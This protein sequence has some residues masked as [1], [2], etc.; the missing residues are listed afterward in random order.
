MEG[1]F[2][3]FRILVSRQNRPLAELLLPAK[4]VPSPKKARSR[5]GTD[6]YAPRSF[7]FRLPLRT[8]RPMYRTDGR[9]C[10]A[11]HT[12]SRVA[13]DGPLAL[14]AVSR[15]RLEPPNERLSLRTPCTH[16]AMD[17]KTPFRPCCS[18]GT[19]AHQRTHAPRRILHA[20]PRTTPPL[21][22]LGTPPFAAPKHTAQQRNDEHITETGTQ[23]KRQGDGKSGPPGLAAR[24]RPPMQGAPQ[25]M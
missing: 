23:P 9:R 25:H 14:R 20:S 2:L 16:V 4:P 24:E 15:S 11:S 22:P 1:R 17:W 8:E 6:L 13:V 12:H 5:N 10:V 18:H 3:G 19:H 21:Y 7:H